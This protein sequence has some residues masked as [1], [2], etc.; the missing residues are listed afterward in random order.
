[1]LLP[2]FF[3]ALTFV[4]SGAIAMLSDSLLLGAAG[5]VDDGDEDRDDCGGGGSGGGGGGGGG[6]DRKDE[7]DCD[8]DE[9]D[10]DVA[11]TME[12]DVE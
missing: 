6:G 11:L 2:G 8:E 9:D 1:M 5:V 7:D 3:S 10:M 12:Q 4:C